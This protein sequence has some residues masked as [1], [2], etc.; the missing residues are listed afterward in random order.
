VTE[1]TESVKGKMIFSKACCPVW[2]LLIPA[3][4]LPKPFPAGIIL[5]A[6]NFVNHKDHEE[7]EE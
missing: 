7:H 4:S 3:Y 1:K 5:P 2:L 6:F